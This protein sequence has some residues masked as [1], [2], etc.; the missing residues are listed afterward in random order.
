VLNNNKI[1]HLPDEIGRLEQLEQLI[2][3]E[4][5][6]TH[7]PGSVKYMGNLLI[8][9]LQNN[10]LL[11]LPPGNDPNPNSNPTYKDIIL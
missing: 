3:S 10:D 8:L 9:K 11:S 1:K 6:L 4:N 2:L 5:K 7:L